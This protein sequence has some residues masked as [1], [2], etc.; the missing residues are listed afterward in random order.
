LEFSDIA[1]SVEKM[2]HMEI[3]ETILFTGYPQL[4]QFNKL[5][6]SRHLPAQLKQELSNSPLLYAKE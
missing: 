1:K 4:K 6:R 2:R 5:Y 3:P